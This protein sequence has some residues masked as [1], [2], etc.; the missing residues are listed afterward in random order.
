MHHRNSVRL[1]A[2][3]IVI[4]STSLFTPHVLAQAALAKTGFDTSTPANSTTT[5][6]GNT[7]RY[8]VGIT[9][10][11]GAPSEVV[12]LGAGEA[13]AGYAVGVDRVFYVVRPASGKSWKF[14]AIAK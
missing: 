14:V 4:A 2:A 5:A 10:P 7:A 9:L 13:M 6:S 8:V 12:A 11:S 1:A 3:A